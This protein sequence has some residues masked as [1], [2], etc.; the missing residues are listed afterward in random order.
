MN[1][2]G[3]VNETSAIYRDIETNQNED[4]HNDEMD[5]IKVIAQKN[6]MKNVLLNS[7]TELL[8]KLL[9]ID[10]NNIKDFNSITDERRKEIIDKANFLRDVYNNDKRGEDYF[11]KFLLEQLYYV[12][13][14]LGLFGKEKVALIIET[15]DPDCEQYKKYSE[16]YDIYKNIVNRE[17][18]EGEKEKILE[19]MEES[20]ENI[21]PEIINVEKLYIKRFNI[22]K[23]SKNIVN[24][25]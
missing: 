5:T 17:L 13:S 3:I 22:N 20:Y 7:Q 19:I 15:I 2:K 23:E 11:F 14:H 12:R 6:I 8:M 24:K 9:L 16:I 4:I 18:D 10:I 21:F 1:I 25:H